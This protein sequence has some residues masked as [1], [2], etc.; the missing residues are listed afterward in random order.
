MQ[1]VISRKVSM[2]RQ[3]NP[4]DEVKVVKIESINSSK[5]MIWASDIC[6]TL[7]LYLGK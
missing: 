7:K 6:Y 3:T 2:A 4:V 1:L 5:A